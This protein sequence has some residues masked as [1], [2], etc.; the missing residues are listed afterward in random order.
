ML[1]YELF[2]IAD[3]SDVLLSQQTVSGC[4]VMFITF[5][6]VMFNANTGNETLIGMQDSTNKWEGWKRKI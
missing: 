2:Q 6:I 3:E 5:I 1:S 4:I